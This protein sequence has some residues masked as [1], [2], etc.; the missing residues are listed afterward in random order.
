MR[1]PMC[2]QFSWLT[3]QAAGVLDGLVHHVASDRP[4]S[5]CSGLLS[6][7]W[8]PSHCNFVSLVEMHGAYSPAPHP[9]ISDDG[10]FCKILLAAS[11]QVSA[12]ATALSHPL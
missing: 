4:K 12:N 3:V 9:K 7:V 8:C 1:I 2:P 10:G 6:V 11:S 5:G